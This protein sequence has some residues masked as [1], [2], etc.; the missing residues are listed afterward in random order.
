MW[1]KRWP[2]TN[3]ENPSHNRLCHEWLMQCLHNMYSY[4]SNLGRFAYC[5]FQ[6][7][8]LWFYLICMY[9][10]GSKDIQFLCNTCLE[11]QL[12]HAT[13]V[14]DPWS[15]VLLWVSPS[16]NK[17]LLMSLRLWRIRTTDVTESSR[18][19][20]FWEALPGLIYV[21]FLANEAKETGWNKPSIVSL[22]QVSL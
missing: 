16:W 17:L 19:K 10:N 20:K 5:A 14:F 21:A 12:H 2:W 13:C 22:L 15:T 11:L 1:G 6:S 7:Y 18:C 3:Q 8:L 4:C 9:D